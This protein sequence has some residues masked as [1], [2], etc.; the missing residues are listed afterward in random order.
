MNYFQAL[1]NNVDPVHL[2]FVHRATEPFTREVP[3]VRAARV[4]DGISMT[5]IRGASREHD[6]LVPAR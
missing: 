4:A 3:E 6:V 2:S 1:E 5:A